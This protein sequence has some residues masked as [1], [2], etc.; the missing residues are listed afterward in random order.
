MCTQFV[1]NFTSSSQ[2]LVIALWQ[3]DIIS[4]GIYF[5]LQI[6]FINFILLMINIYY[7]MFDYFI[8]YFRIIYLKVEDP[9]KIEKLN[10]KISG[11]ESCKYTSYETHLHF[12]FLQ[13]F[14][15]SSVTYNLRS[16]LVKGHKLENVTYPLQLKYF[17]VWTV[18]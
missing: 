13:F 18:C 1:F 8:F 5:I 3:K 10:L 6:Y 7:F 16:R 4:V 11:I 17:A 2:I 12:R 15:L 14:N 9:D